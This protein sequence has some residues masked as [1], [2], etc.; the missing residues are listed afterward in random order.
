RGGWRSRVPWR[1]ARSRNTLAAENERL[2]QRLEEESVLAGRSAPMTRLREEVARAA[3]TTATV[4]IVGES[5]TGKELV[6][7]EIHR[8]SRVAG[9]S[10]IPNK[11]A[12]IPPELT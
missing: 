4:L 9:D 11:S 3:P 6:A 2:R 5:G 10:F 7:R 1:N 12:A 8:G